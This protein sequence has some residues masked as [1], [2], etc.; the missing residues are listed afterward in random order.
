MPTA[1]AGGGSRRVGS[2]PQARYPRRMA[3][4]GGEPRGRSESVGEPEVPGPTS[5]RRSPGTW[6]HAPR[7]KLSVL[8][9]PPPGSSCGA[10]LGRLLKG[11]RESRPPPP[12]APRGWGVGGS[13][14]GGGGKPSSGAECWGDSA[15]GAGP[16]SPRP[17]SVFAPAQRSAAE[18]VW[19][20]AAQPSSGALC[21]DQVEALQA[22]SAL[23][24][25]PS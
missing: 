6:L 18:K 19:G 8:F 24:T 17:N 9:P 20:D 13:G 4:G 3:R 10:S 12:P 7:R 16:G 15:V 2:A 22:Q 11:H 21:T 5:G 25:W 1:R 23:Q 14:R